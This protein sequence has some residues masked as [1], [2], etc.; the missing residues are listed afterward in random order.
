MQSKFFGKLSNRPIWGQA[1]ERFFWNRHLLKL[2]ITKAQ[3]DP[4]NGV[5]RFVTYFFSFFFFS[6]LFFSF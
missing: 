4:E 6:F 5:I 2:L 1:D 3:E